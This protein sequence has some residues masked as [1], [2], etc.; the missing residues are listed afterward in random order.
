MTQ[1][2][3]NPEEFGR[4][5]D[6]CAATLYTL[7]NESMRVRITDFGGRIVSVEVPDRS[8]KLDHVVLGFD[9]VSKY[10]SAGGSF[11]ALLG[12]TANRIGGAAF[13]LDGHTYRLSKN[14]ERAT[15]HGGQQ[16]FDKL[17][18]QVRPAARIC[19]WL[20]SAPTATKDFRGSC[21]S[22]LGIRWT[23]TRFGCRWRRQPTNLLRSASAL[24][25]ISIWPV[26]QPAT[27]TDTR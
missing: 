2:P 11:G 23:E 24:I 19:R 13:T 15:L 7:S 25:P 27:S 16:G 4:T 26:F 17:F 9:D 18:W 1:H 14:E 12:R 6:G 3:K 22:K 20:W 21:R 8:G 10:V 5:A